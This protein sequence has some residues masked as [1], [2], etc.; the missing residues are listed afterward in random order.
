[1]YYTN[2]GHLSGGVYI[3]DEKHWQFISDII[4]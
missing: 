3:V 2:G 1:M 4:R